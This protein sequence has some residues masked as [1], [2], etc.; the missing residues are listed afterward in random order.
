V[1]K[2]DRERFEKLLLEQ[3]EQLASQHGQMGDA[4]RRTPRESSGELSAYTHHMAD[5]GTDAMAREQS[6]LLA[7][8]LSRTL[9]EIDDALQRIKGGGFGVCEVCRRPI[10]PKRLQALPYARDCIGCR[11]DRDRRGDAPGAGRP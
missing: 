9:S 5:L 10:E 8:N 7:A 4:A 3:R 6:F 2:R 1:R 11:E